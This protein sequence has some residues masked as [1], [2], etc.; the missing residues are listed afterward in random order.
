MQ[1]WVRRNG[2]LR[3]FTKFMRNPIELPGVG[4]G[5]VVPHEVRVGALD[6]LLEA[7]TGDAVQEPE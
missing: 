5:P 6:R 1:A 3:G 4:D 7:I 2:R